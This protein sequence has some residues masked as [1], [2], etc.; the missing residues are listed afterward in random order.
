MKDIIKQKLKNLPDKPGVYIMKDSGGAIIYVG[1]AKILKNRVRQYFG[2][3]T[4]HTPKVRAMVEKIED[5]EYIITDSE[6]EALCLECNLIKQNQPKYNILLKDDKHYPFIKISYR[7]E[8]PKMSL[9]RKIEDDGAKYFGPY[10]NSA[11]VYTT[12]DTVSKMFG[13]QQCKKRFPRDIGKERPCLYHSIGKCMAPCSGEIT[14]EEYKKA[15]SDVERF[16]EGKH[17]DL[18][19]KLE[20]EMN[21]AAEKLEFERAARMRDKINNIR[22]IMSNQKVIAG[23]REDIDVFATSIDE[24]LS[25]FEIFFIRH[26]KLIG[27]ESYKQSSVL[28]TSEGDVL[29]EFVKAY[30]NR[31]VFVPDKVLCAQSIHDSSEISEWLSQK[32]EK[33][34]K[35]SVPQRGELRK[36]A[37]M[38]TKNCRHNIAEYKIE[39]LSKMNNKKALGE[40]AKLLGIEIPHRIEAY[41]ISNTSGVDN[42]GSMVVFEDGEKA[43]DQ[44]R[45]F[46][47]KYIVGANDYDC[48]KEV[49]VRRFM[50]YH[51]DEES[52]F[53]KLPDLILIDG[54][55]GHVAAAKEALSHLAIDVKTFGMVKDSKHRT[56]GLTTDKDELS[57]E[58]GSPAMRLV[59]RIQDEAHRFAITYHKKLR[60]KRNLKSD[61]I[62]IKGIGEAK[63]KTLMKHFKSVENIKNA[64][65]EEIASVK[66]IDKASAKNIFDY[67]KEKSLQIK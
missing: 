39:I 47:I 6:F 59:T 8:Y 48:M 11:I 30:Y 33:K 19:K 17:T 42:V 40:L 20:K 25:V 45:R 13:L 22:G 61:L 18:L 28:A 52:S 16:L 67:F 65:Y 31:D 55:K 12:I 26:G 56:R 3:G 34:V 32:R 24:D 64:S 58:I 41:D 51:E 63:A 66:G 14:A 29:T 23:R 44:Y 35:V 1:K 57:V 2:K 37:D 36:I 60:G 46:K 10:P 21:L 53:K 4:N 7:E 50:H 15:F 62:N 27:N 43:T 49:L 38:A 5:F 9:T 54:G